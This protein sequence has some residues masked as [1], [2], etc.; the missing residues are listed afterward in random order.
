MT[1]MI[2]ISDDED[3]PIAPPRQAI[4]SRPAMPP[5]QASSS[6][7]A[8]SRMI[9]ESET[10]TAE[11]D[12]DME[13]DTEERVTN[14]ES[15]STH[16]GPS[17]T[18]SGSK[19]TYDP[20]STA[21]GTKASCRPTASSRSAPSSEKS[22]KKSKSNSSPVKHAPSA[23]SSVSPHKRQPLF[24]SPSP[25]AGSAAALPTQ[26]PTSR[27]APTYRPTWATE[28]PADTPPPSSAR[29]STAIH[30]ERE[31]K[32][33]TPKSAPASTTPGTVATKPSSGSNAKPVSKGMG[34]DRGKALAKS[35]VMESLR[36]LTP[37]TSGPDVLDV[38]PR[39]EGGTPIGKGRMQ[40]F[41]E[42]P[43]RP[44]TMT[45]TKAPGAP[46]TAIV[47]TSQSTAL[48]QR[49]SRMSDDDLDILDSGSSQGA[50]DGIRAQ[51]TSTQTAE[52]A[53][54][55]EQDGTA[56]NLQL[57]TR[58]E[59]LEAGPS[60]AVIRDTALVSAALVEEVIEQTA[61]EVKAVDIQAKPLSKPRMTREI[62]PDSGDENATA[63]PAQSVP[64]ATPTRSGVA[65]NEWARA[66]ADKLQGEQRVDQVKAGGGMDFDM[67]APAK[68]VAK[69]SKREL[70][71]D[72]DDDFDPTAPYGD[73]DD[74]V[75]DD[76][77]AAKRSGGGGFS[78]QGAAAAAA[79]AR[80]SKRRADKRQRGETSPAAAV[81]SEQFST[82]DN[83][84]AGP[85]KLPAQMA[86]RKRTIF[87]LSPS[88]DPIMITNRNT[89]VDLGAE[90]DPMCLLDKAEDETKAVETIELDDDDD[91]PEGPGRLKFR[92]DRLQEMTKAEW[93]AMVRARPRNGSSLSP[94]DA[95]LSLP[96]RAGPHSNSVDRAES[97]IAKSH[98]S[99]TVGRPI[100]IPP[101]P[102]AIAT[103]G[104]ELEITPLRYRAPVRREFETRTIDLY[105]LMLPQLTANPDLHRAM[106]Q[107]WISEA[108]ACDEP[109]ADEIRVYNEADI[110]GEAP[111]MEFEYSNQMLYDHDV[112]DP[113]VGTG[114]G[115]Q[116]PCDPKSR[117]CSCVKRQK[118]YCYDL[119]IEGFAYES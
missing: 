84:I 28:P 97:T 40:A 55:T 58:S 87:E 49:E 56:H 46:N 74:A 106:F 20:S 52:E 69:W 5:A 71:P 54:I 17:R 2:V 101:S 63:L 3:D 32:A 33:S 88:P 111:A 38:I 81:E 41:V 89:P 99:G 53:P 113:E 4:S 85:S 14:A 65:V 51:D 15:R 93:R 95:D 72:S 21:M 8:P 110:E 68:T 7:S 18:T 37:T 42:L 96:R 100:E 90:M 10:S 23:S 82:S 9:P 105:N 119:P 94:I 60:R 78:V 13:V 92:P 83:A 16:A 117:T 19:R 25:E 107:N 1:A 50:D 29:Q 27:S 34:K 59:G 109:H 31:K 76:G 61:D 114:C 75:M 11:R 12:M 22:R 45:S 36:Q 64:S 115:C 6:S 70:S 62:S 118:L 77:Q 26:K 66:V 80:W 43:T 57:D 86:E 112:P 35:P 67:D 30:T 98:R 79:A 91:E 24:L 108:T 116:G 48:P 39:A 104:T 47:N 103:H 44:Q 102:S 73:G